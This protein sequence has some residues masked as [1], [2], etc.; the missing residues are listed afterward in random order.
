MGSWAAEAPTALQSRGR[1]PRT[2]CSPADLEVWMRGQG[3]EAL[4]P[5]PA[6]QVLWGSCRPACP[7]DPSLSDSVE[8][9][10][11]SAGLMAALW[12]N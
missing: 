9:F 8:L 7:Q 4:Q 5:R 2:T 1:S 3:W 12:P 11:T 10:R 6:G